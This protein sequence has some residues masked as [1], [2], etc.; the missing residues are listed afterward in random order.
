MER[1]ENSHEWL[2]PSVLSDLPQLLREILSGESTE[3]KFAGPVLVSSN[4][5]ANRFILQRYGI[6]PSQRK[7]YKSL[8]AQVRQHCRS[9][10]EYTLRKKQIEV[11]HEKDRVVFGAFR[12]DSIRGNII[13]GF[14]RANSGEEWIV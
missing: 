10:F 2:T 12:Y 4:R 5:L 9:L 7:Q 11:L 8:F 13:L 6:R 3:K 1:A 14:I